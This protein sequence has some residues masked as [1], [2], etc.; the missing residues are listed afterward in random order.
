[1]A[2]GDVFRVA[3]AG[4]VG[5]EPWMTTF[6]LVEGSGAP[7]GPNPLQDAAAAVATALGGS[8]LVDFSNA[9]T[10][11]DIIVQ[12]VQPGTAGSSHNPV[13]FTGSGTDPI[14]APQDAVVI[15]W[16]TA[17]AGPANR[18]RMY[19]PGVPSN[20]AINGYVQGA[21][22]D[23]ISAFASLL[24]DPFAA[25]GTDYQLNVLSYTPGS[26]PRT[27][28]AA[29]PITSFS[30][31]NTVKSQRRRGVGVRIGRPCVHEIAMRAAAKAG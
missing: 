26:S 29:V 3:L 12:D 6:G 14:V 15:S 7:G 27:L 30:I 5:T 19:I 18:G 31:D 20:G 1:M 25:D 13:A 16:R 8:P 23:V 22:Q 9:M 2:L 28:R 17:L 24:F 10:I 4:M 21:W 11:T